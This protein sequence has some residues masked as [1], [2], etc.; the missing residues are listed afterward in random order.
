M[1]TIAYNSRN[2]DFLFIGTRTKE[3]AQDAIDNK[4]DNGVLLKSTNN[5]TIAASLRAR[6]AQLK[7]YNYCSIVASAKC[8]TKRPRL[9]YDALQRS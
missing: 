7:E 6:N 3:A 4:G 8:P 2:G 1:N 5:T 9:E